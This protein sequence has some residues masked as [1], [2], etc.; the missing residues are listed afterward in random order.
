MVGNVFFWTVVIIGMIMFPVTMLLLKGS[1]KAGWIKGCVFGIN[2][3]TNFVVVKEE[4]ENKVCQIHALSFY[5][6]FFTI[7]MA[8]SVERD[9]LEATGDGE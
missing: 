3:S 4:E 5:I 1:F 8:F 2:Y 6:F 9:D 7:T